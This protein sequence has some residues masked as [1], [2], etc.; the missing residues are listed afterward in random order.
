MRGAK[1]L[2]IG[3]WMLFEIWCSFSCWEPLSVIHFGRCSAFS[4]PPPVR[5]GWKISTGRTESSRARWGFGK[6][7]KNDAQMMHDWCAFVLSIFCQ[8]R[9]HGWWRIIS[10][11]WVASHHGRFPPPPHTT[12]EFGSVKLLGLYPTICHHGGCW[13]FSFTGT[14]TD[15]EQLMADILH[16]LG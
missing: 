10:G 12:D 1:E 5:R 15:S 13:W 4:F 3:S 9:I 2:A 14:S 16:H 8:I 7:K 6:C 11:R